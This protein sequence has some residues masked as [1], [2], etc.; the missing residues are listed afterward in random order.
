MK[1]GNAPSFRASAAALRKDKRFAPLVR[2]HGVPDLKRGV[3]FFRALT[4]AIIYQQLSGKA[5][6]TIASRFVAL[7][8][9][10]KKFPSPEA[11]LTMPE[12]RLRSAGLSAQKTAYIRDV[13]RTFS[14]GTIRRRA[15]ARMA[16]DDIVA[17]LTQIKGV[18]EWTAQMFLIFTLNR[19]DVLP[20]GD[21][22][23][24]KG[25]QIVYGLRRLP[26]AAAM[27]RLAAPWR[28]HATAASWYLWRAADEARSTGAF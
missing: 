24:Q 8:G 10:G 5:A 23:I 22:G 27:E 16:S 2:K 13:A 15:L 9:G 17:H 3:N 26:S 20:T 1:K 28:A 11:V 21:L 12:E 7:F 14:D 18:G 25:F 19:P 6:A 4:E